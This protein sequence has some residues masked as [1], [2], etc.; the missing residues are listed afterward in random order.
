MASD[1]RRRSIDRASRALNAGCTPRGTRVRRRWRQ[2]RSL[3]LEGNARTRPPIYPDHTCAPSGRFHSR[4]GTAKADSSNTWQDVLRTWTKGRALK[5]RDPQDPSA[6]R[7]DT[8]DISISLLKMTRD[9][10]VDL[11]TRW[12]TLSQTVYPRTSSVRCVAIAIIT[13]LK[14]EFIS[15]RKTEIFFSSC[16]R[17]KKL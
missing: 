14:C 9:T 17:I 2:V 16:R 13:D 11:I 5:E 15:V 6:G 8:E 4:R 10:H 1:E 7:L 3:P 12:R